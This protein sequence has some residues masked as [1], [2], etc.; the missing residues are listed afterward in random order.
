MSRMAARARPSTEHEPNH[1]VDAECCFR[2]FPCN[3]TLA[4]KLTGPLASMASQPPKHAK[5]KKTL[6]KNKGF[7]TPL[8]VTWASLFTDSRGSPSGNPPG[9]LS[10]KHQP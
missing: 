8:R 3:K 7:D 2:E 5:T 1:I 10:K 6:S 4:S 9:T